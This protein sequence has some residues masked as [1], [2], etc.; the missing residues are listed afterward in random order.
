MDL[1]HLRNTFYNIFQQIII[2]PDNMRRLRQGNKIKKNEY[3]VKAL[4]LQYTFP[5]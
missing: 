5:R 1:S 4:M 3:H 2:L